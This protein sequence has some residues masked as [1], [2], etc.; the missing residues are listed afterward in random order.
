MKIGG[1]LIVG[2]LLGLAGGLIYTWFIAPVQYYDTYPPML[3]PRH[4]QEWIGMAAWTY[5]LEGNWDRT[6]TRLLHLP[7]SEV[8][9]G[10]LAVLEEA[11]V[12]GQ[13]MEVLQRLARL[14][15]AYGA[16]GPGVAIYTGTT[17]APSVTESAPPARATTPPTPL[18]P[19]PSATA[20]ASALPTPMPTATRVPTGTL[21]LAPSSPFTIISQTLTCELEPRI[22]VS[23]EVSRTVTERGRERSEIT[24]LPNRELWLIWDSG[25]DRAITGFR[26]EIGLGYADFVVEPGHTYNLYIDAPI[27]LPILTLRIEPCVISEEGWV[28]RVLTVREAEILDPEDLPKETPVATRPVPPAGTATAPPAEGSTPTPTATLITPLA[29]AR[30]E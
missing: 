25:A 4:R 17:L 11:V 30:E 21:D 19:L 26:P 23:L 15:S 12:L 13:T 24:G 6:Q 10:A 14:A 27:G 28:S 5:S 16:T 29:P 3:S 1:A 18:L 9:D 7:E 22:A 20:V 8:R 2:L